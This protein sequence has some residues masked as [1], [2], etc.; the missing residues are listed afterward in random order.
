MY[1]GGWG[2]R[3]TYNYPSPRKRITSWLPNFPKKI[4][5]SRHKNTFFRYA[6]KS[7]LNAL[8][9]KKYDFFRGGGDFRCFKRNFLNL[10]SRLIFG[11]STLSSTSFKTFSTPPPLK[12]YPIIYQSIFLV[13]KVLFIEKRGGDVDEIW[14]G[15]ER[16]GGHLKGNVN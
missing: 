5:W 9:K 7:R 15:L 10:I 2:S 14:I 3:S 1:F 6:Q 16:G 11:N 13:H 4:L 12:L 8:T